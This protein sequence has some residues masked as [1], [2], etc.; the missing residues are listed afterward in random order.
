MGTV[1]IIKLKNPIVAQPSRFT[2]R[3]QITSA[4]VL[5]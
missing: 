5:E 4:P 2:A 1:S 3:N